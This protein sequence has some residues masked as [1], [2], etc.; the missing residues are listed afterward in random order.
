MQ[1]KIQ[2]KVGVNTSGAS[3]SLYV[4]QVTGLWFPLVKFHKGKKIYM[5]VAVYD[6]L[7]TYGQELKFLYKTF[8][9]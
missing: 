5:L 4:S 9:L 3:L 8:C 2:H 6:T 7:P 1:F